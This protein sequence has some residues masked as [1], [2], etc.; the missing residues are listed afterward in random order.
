V[1]LFI[2]IPSGY[3]SY[4]GASGKGSIFSA[5]RQI[6]KPTLPDGYF[7]PAI[8]SQSMVNGLLFAAAFGVQRG[9]NATPGYPQLR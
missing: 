3:I 1:S 9:A 2:R 6:N 5:T 7:S 8:E 4:P